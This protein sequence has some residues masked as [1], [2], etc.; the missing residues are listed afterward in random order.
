M[1]EK[2]LTVEEVAEALCITPKTIRKYLREGRIPAAKFGR[3]YRIGEST[4]GK[5]LDGTIT[6]RLDS[7]ILKDL[8]ECREGR[9]LTPKEIAHK[10]RESGVD[11]EYVNAL[12]AD[13]EDK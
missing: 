13:R 11:L 1:V 5:I 3:V 8:R 6:L 12:Q 10:Y 9:R 2:A 4:I 7:H